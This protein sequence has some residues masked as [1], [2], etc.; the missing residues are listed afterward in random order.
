M[1]RPWISPS[2]LLPLRLGKLRPWLTD[3]HGP[4][5]SWSGEPPP[6]RRTGRALGARS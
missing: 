2:A 3:V 5:N 6:H 1:A 4:P